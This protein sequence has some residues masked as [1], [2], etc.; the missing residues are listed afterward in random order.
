MEENEYKATYRQ[1][2]QIPCVYEKALTHLKARCEL[3]RH[4]WLADRE[5]YA[6]GSEQASANCCKLLE[7]LREKARF[8]L[9][10]KEVQNQLPHNMEIRI[11]AGGMEAL[12]QLAGLPAG[13]S[14]HHVVERLQQR[15]GGIEAIP[16]SDIMPAIAAW[17]GRKR[18]RPNKSNK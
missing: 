15:Q 8:A 18:R 4:F 14:I 10:L 9:K 5:G 2:T 12:C 1:L 11:Q 16:Y 17:Q 6:C 3:A 13:S 7:S